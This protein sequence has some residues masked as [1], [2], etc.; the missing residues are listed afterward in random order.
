MVLATF[1]AALLLA[2]VHLVAG[3]LRFLDGVPRSRW[4][5]GAGGA[6]VA[7]IFLHVLPELAAHQRGMAGER[8]VFLIALAG[9]VAFYGLER[10]ARCARARQ[11][12]AGRAEAPDRETFWLHV[13]S[14]AVYN[15]VLGYLLHRRQDQGPW[16]L[17][18]YASAIAL[19]FVVT[20]WGMRHHLR[21]AWDR[22]ARW[23]LGAAVLAG[24][25]LGWAVELP[26]HA[27]GLAFA[28]LAGGIVLNVL[29]EELP[30]ERESRFAPFVA[31]AAL[32]G[33][34]LLVAA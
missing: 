8:T 13:A 30:E 12:R 34:V 2:V 10:H 19:H 31:G 17:V 14:F 21:R 6:S 15:V 22:H 33:G 18:T 9:L 28:F 4:L 16:P 24:W 1:G 23:A 25:A 7:Y 3:K 29:K 20:D 11:R 5:S 27:V 32:Y 26:T